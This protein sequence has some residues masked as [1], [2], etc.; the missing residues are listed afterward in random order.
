MVLEVPRK[1]LGNAG[2][3]LDFGFKWCDDNLGDGD[4]LTLYTDG[5]AA[6]GGRFVFR[7]ATKPSEKETSPMPF[8]IAGAA[9]FA[10]AGAALVIILVMKSKKGRIKE[11]APENGEN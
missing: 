1:L 3:T 5:D 4:I 7:F 9:A 11:T 10:V 2:K 6:P 8:I